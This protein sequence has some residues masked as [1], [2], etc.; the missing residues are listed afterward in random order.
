MAAMDKPCICPA[1]GVVD[2]FC[3]VHERFEWV[4]FDSR[5][6]PL[7][8]SFNKFRDE[9]VHDRLT[10]T[11]LKFEVMRLIAETLAKVPSTMLGWTPERLKEINDLCTK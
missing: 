11:R 3:P 1:P 5:P 7:Q 9:I 8:A 4:D 10:L 2:P 6:T